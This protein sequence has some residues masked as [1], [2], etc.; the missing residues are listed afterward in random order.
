MAIAS[1]TR[2]GCGER[3]AVDG[4][5]DLE[6]AV[7]AADAALAVDH[8]RDLVVAAGDPAVGA[9]F[10]QREGEVARRV[11]GDRERSRGRRAMRPARRDADDRV[12]VRELGVVVDELRRHREVAR[13]PL[14]VLLAQG[15]QLVA[16]AAALRSCGG[17]LV[18]DERI[19]VM[20]ADRDGSRPD[21]VTSR[22]GRP[23]PPRVRTR[24]AVAAVAVRRPV[25]IARRVRLRSPSRGGYDFRSPSRGGYDFRSP[26]RGGYGFSLTIAGRVRLPLTIARRVRTSAHHRAAGTTSAHHR[27][28]GTT[29]AH[30]RA[31]GTDFRSPSR[32]GYDFVTITRRVRLPLTIARRVRLPLAITRRVRLRSPSRGGTT[33]AHHHEA[34]TTSLTVT[35]RIRLPLAIARRVRLR[36][37]SRGGYDFRSPSRGGYDFRSPSRGGY[38]FRSPSR[39]GYDFVAIALRVRLAVASGASATASCRRRRREGALIAA[40][41]RLAIAPVVARLLFCHLSILPGARCSGAITAVNA[42]WPP[43]AGWPFLERSPAVSYS[44]TGSPLQYHRR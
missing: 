11:G 27:A 33:S 20:R 44:P 37:P 32:G 5:A 12:L 43:S 25:A 23:A 35:R 3:A 31:A 22:S 29:S 17:D 41:T 15:L 40:R 38:D 28:A 39:G 26:S 34:G 14:G 6:R 36:S 13:D 42:K 30:H 18:G 9:Q 24:A 10:A 8:E 7:G 21:D 4:A 19:V 2:T 16:R 1:S